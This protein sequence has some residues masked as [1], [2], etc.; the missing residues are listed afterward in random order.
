MDQTIEKRKIGVF[1]IEP[2]KG[3]SGK[4]LV[5]NRVTDAVHKTYGTWSEVE[6]QTKR[7]ADLWEARLQQKHKGLLIKYNV[8]P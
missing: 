8:Y 7:M 4:W 5:T 6:E 2:I 3:E 1:E